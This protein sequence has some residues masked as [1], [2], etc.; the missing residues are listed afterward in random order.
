MSLKRE[1]KKLGACQEAVDWV[2]KRSL[3]VA[4][5][6]CER[7]DWMLWYAALK[8][9]HKLVVRAACACARTALKYVPQNEKRPLLA[10]EITEEWFN[11]KATLKQVE[12]AGA[13]AWVAARAAAEAAEAAGAA[14]RKAWAAEAAGAAA[15]ATARTAWASEAAGAAAGAAAVAEAAGAAARA[16]AASEAAGALGTAQAMKNMADIVRSI[17]KIEEK[18]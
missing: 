9:N 1:L 16:A 17:I 5:A 13:A 2:G 6:E 8:L 15:W 3:R 11:G 14:A 7:A 4:W 18:S 10:I 12:V